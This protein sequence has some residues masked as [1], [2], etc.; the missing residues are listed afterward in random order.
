MSHMTVVNAKVPA[1]HKA[2]SDLVL[3]EAD[4]TWSSVIQ[5]LARYMA[6]VREVPTVLTHRDKG[7]EI[8]RKLIALDASCGWV[9]SGRQ[10]TD[11]ESKA[12]INEAREAR[13]G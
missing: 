4:M 3:S 11:D 5:S 2:E 9:D 10:L 7:A 12:M 8:S 6:E 13:H 1:I